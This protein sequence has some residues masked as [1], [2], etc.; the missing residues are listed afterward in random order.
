MRTTLLS[1]LALLIATVAVVSAGDD[2]SPRISRQRDS[3]NAALAYWQAQ[4]CLLGLVPDISNPST[5]VEGFK[6]IRD[7]HKAPLNEDAREAIRRSHMTLYF[8]R[9]GSQIKRCEWGLASDELGPADEQGHLSSMPLLVGAA[10][11]RARHFF[12]KDMSAEGVSDLIALLRLAKHSGNAG[13]D[14][15]RAI[16]AQLSTETRAIELAARRISKI[17]AA[18]IERL[19]LEMTVLPISEI[20]KNFLAVQKKQWVHWPREFARH[21][22]KHDGDWDSYWVKVGMRADYR[23]EVGNLLRDASN[24]DPDRLLVLADEAERV[25][26]QGISLADMPP[27]EFRRA[28]LS[29]FKKT[30]DQN[31]IVELAGGEVELILDGLILANGRRSLFQAGVV[32]SR[33]GPEMLNDTEDSF[34]PFEYRKLKDGF[35]LTANLGLRGRALT[36]FFGQPDND[37]SGS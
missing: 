14:G 10:C 6:I 12:E 18:G 31:L 15:N 9:R 27:D 24:G 8:L 3:G 21:V 17:D 33:K 34:G 4:E 7:G 22:R 28:W 19:G 2:D 37:A 36:M 23:A 26:E 35:E 20:L 13:H 1:L 11:L 32:V 29:L 30:A 5:G 25:F 16:L